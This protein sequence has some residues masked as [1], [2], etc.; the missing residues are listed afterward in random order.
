MVGLS[1]DT[2][3]NIARIREN[4]ANW[5]FLHFPKH[6][7]KPFSSNHPR[8]DFDPLPGDKFLALKAF[9]CVSAILS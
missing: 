5:Q 6:L 9:R 8:L 7:Q 4:P 1:F 3:K 2:G